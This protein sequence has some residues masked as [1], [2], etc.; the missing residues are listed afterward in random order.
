[1]TSGT[2]RSAVAAASSADLFQARL[3]EDQGVDF[4]AQCGNALFARR[5]WA[6]PVLVAGWLLLTSVGFMWWRAQAEKDTEENSSV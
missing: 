1:M 2:Y 6:I 3:A 5:V 4:I